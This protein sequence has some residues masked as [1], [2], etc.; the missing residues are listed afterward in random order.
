MGSIDIR[1]G[2]ANYQEAWKRNACSNCAHIKRDH[3]ASDISQSSYTCGKHNFFVQ[4]FS[5][6]DH[7]E[8]L[9]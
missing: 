5:I 7:Y 1:K 8:A 6:C 9:T 3:L 4:K 2:A